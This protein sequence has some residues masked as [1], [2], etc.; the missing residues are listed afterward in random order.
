MTRCPDIGPDEA[1]ELN[2]CYV[3]GDVCMVCAFTGYGWYWE[4][5]LIG[6]RTTTCEQWS[7]I[8]PY[9]AECVDESSGL[10][11]VCTSAIS[12]PVCGACGP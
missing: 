12:A 6:P 11:C 9:P 10:C 8:P 4:S 7:C 1:L 3:G 5:G 2:C